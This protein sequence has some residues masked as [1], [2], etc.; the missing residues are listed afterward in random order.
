[1]KLKVKDLCSFMESWAPAGYAAS[2][3]RVGLH[4]G[5]PESEVH[6]V[7]VSLSVTSETVQEAKR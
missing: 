1:M 6:T 4:T 2:W 7:L 5:H 3:D